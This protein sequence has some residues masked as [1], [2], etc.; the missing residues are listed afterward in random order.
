[1]IAVAA[2]HFAKRSLSAGDE[3]GLEFIGLLVFRDPLK[4]S[5]KKAIEMARKL[6]VDV[7]IITGDSIETAAAV[8]REVGLIDDNRQVVDA[9]ELEVLPAREF[10]QACRRVRVFARAT[11]AAK[12]RIVEALERRGEVGF[13]GEGINDVPSLRAANVG[14]VVDQATDAAKA[15]ADIVILSRDLKVIVEGI[16]LG[17]T[18]FSNVQ[19]YIKCT[20]ASNSGGAVFMA[21]ASLAVPF[22]PMLPL[23]ILLINVLSDFVLIAIIY[24]AVE[25]REL[26][27]PKSYHLGQMLPLA[28]ILALVSVA[29]GFV[30]LAVFGAAPAPEFQTLWFVASV[31]GQTALIF[32]VRTSGD[33]WRAKRPGRIM[34]ALA[35]LVPGIAASLPFL[36]VGQKVFGMAPPRPENFAL[37]ALLV[38]GYFMASESA[39]RIYYRFA[40]GR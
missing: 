11:P 14:L 31:A 26:L 25:P 20:L 37:M 15:E 16:R 39:K 17:R 19:K 6:R 30:F 8:G 38:A 22:L 24:D 21:L 13:L 10:E 9:R 34:I 4:A 18:V 28:G 1:M 3:R 35:L 2:R 27:A 23:Q 32:S 5:S 29:F 36:P 40:L 33:F 12:Y 7:K